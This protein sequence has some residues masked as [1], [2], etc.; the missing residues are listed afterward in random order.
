MTLSSEAI[1]HTTDRYRDAAGYYTTGRPGYPPLL[2]KRVA[3]LLGVDRRQRVIDLGTGPGFLAIGFAGYAGEVLGIDPSAEMLAAAGENARQAGVTVEFVAGRSSDLEPRF[4]PARL[5][6]IGRAFHWMDTVD[7]L[8]RLDGIVD[9]DGAV[10]LFSDRSPNVA[11]NVWRATFEAVRERYA[12][13]DRRQKPGHASHLGHGSSR[14]DEVLLASAFSAVER[15]S[16][17]DR[18]ATPLERFVD[19]ALSFG[20]TWTGASTTLVEDLSAEL[21]AAL[22]PY[23]VDGVIHEVIEGQATIARRPAG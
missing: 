18:R 11:E 10:A 8:R 23:A 9:P 21:T 17:L 6:T 14:Y 19:R 3:D 12:A 1:S 7:T 5:V 22:A 2:I 13:E 15:I 16:V 20:A 4:G